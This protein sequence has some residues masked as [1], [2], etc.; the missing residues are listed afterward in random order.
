M[1]IGNKYGFDSG[2]TLD[3]VYANKAEGKTFVGRFI[4]YFLVC[5]FENRKHIYL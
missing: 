1:S 2:V 3:H 5:S 4:V